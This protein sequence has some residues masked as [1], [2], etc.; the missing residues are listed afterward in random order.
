MPC[1]VYPHYDRLPPPTTATLVIKDMAHE[2]QTGVGTHASLNVQCAHYS[3]APCTQLATASYDGSVRLLDVAVGQFLD[4]TPGI[5]EDME[6]S[7]MELGENGR[8]GG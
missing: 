3:G 5:R 7:A 1:I 8:W 2:P 4:L 6:I